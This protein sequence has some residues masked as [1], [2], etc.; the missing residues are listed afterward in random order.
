MISKNK[1]IQILI[2]LDMNCDEFLVLKN[3]TFY[4]NYQ[5]T[6]HSASEEIK[7][8]LNKSY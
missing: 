3:L 4:K 8:N 6:H 5:N 2:I 1:S 7:L